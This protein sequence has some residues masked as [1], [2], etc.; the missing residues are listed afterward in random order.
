MDLEL[1]HVDETQALATCG[2][3]V[4]RIVMSAPTRVEDID[5]VITLVDAVL[6]RSPTAGLWVVVHHGAPLP[7]AHVRDH[8]THQFRP[9][10]DR[11]CTTVSMLGLG[12]WAST[13]YK[14]TAAFTRLAKRSAPVEASV[15]DG[16]RRLSMELIG[17]DADALIAAHDELSAQMSAGG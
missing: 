14:V 13:A 5:H 10:E 9:Y 8:A 17:I 2:A 12:F 4:M 16:A 1:H 15:A 3:V 6:E 11:L 7:P